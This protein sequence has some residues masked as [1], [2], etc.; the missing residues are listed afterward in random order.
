MKLRFYTILTLTVGL[1]ACCFAACGE[2]ENKLPP[3]PSEED[4]KLS[5]PSNVE[6]FVDAVR[7]DSVEHASEYEVQ[8]GQ[9]SKTVS[10]EYF[11]L[12]SWILTGAYEIRV[13][14]KAEGYEDSEWSEPV[15]LII[16][17][18]GLEFTLTKDG[19]GYE[20]SRGTANVNNTHVYIPS[21][22]NGLPVVA[23][24][25]E[26]FYQCTRLRGVTLPE[27][28]SSFGKYAFNTCSQ[29]EEVNIPEAVT[30]LEAAVFIKCTSL[31]SIVL[32]KNLKVIGNSVFRYCTVLS[33]ISF[34]DALEKIG[35]CAFDDT[36][37][38]DAQ[39][40]GP[41]YIGTILY[42]YRTS[43]TGEFFVDN[44]HE[45][46]TY[47]VGAAFYNLH[48]LVGVNLPESV[49]GIGQSAF[50]ECEKLRSVVLPSNLEELGEAAFKQCY[51]LERI[52]IPN[53][54]KSPIIW[55]GMCRALKEI[56]YTGT[57]E[58]WKKIEYYYWDTHL[59]NDYV[60]KCTD[61]EIR[62]S[63]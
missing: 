5:T 37:W 48:N 33:E 9:T 42:K 35:V 14:A 20:V 21:F 46:T 25:E 29:M 8:V 19:S 40:D 62:K 41:I 12:S 58:E 2:L 28:V 54:V 13:M 4:L 16:G 18:K 34:P 3:P 53:T 57:M 23:V 11:D 63:V 50:E 22:Y 6:L 59:P 36:A 24:A 17:T 27:S 44:I 1:A 55:F 49:K 26:A 39:P 30:E 60:V 31:K 61:G 45:D 38:Y 10:V 7:W 47:I 51:A 43:E 56:V 52:V 32:P 15:R